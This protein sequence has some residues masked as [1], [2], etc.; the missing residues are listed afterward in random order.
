MQSRTPS[1]DCGEMKMKNARLLAAAAVMGLMPLTAMAQWSDNFDS[2]LAGSI[3]GQGGWKGWDNTP[4]AAGTVVTAQSLSG[5][6]SQAIATN[7]DSVREYTGVTSGA[8]TYSTNIYIPQGTTGQTYFIL[9]NKYQDAGPGTAY[10]WSSELLF[11]LTTNVVYDDLANVGTPSPGSASIPLV[12]GQWVPVRVDFNLT[13]DTFSS[14][15]NNTLVYSGAW[16][17]GSATAAA[18]LKAVDLYHA[19]GTGTV[20]YDNF[21]LVPAP[22]S[23]S[24]LALGGLLAARRRRA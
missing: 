7:S 8:W 24:L 14:Y 12:R 2:Y 15:Y 1:G 21:N 4:A 10:N 13:A 19:S 9:L 20:Y 22:A 17:R 3:Q 23:M 5:P 6:H 11:N 16:K 18:E